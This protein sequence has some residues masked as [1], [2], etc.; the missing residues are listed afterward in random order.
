VL[1]HRILSRSYRYNGREDA[2]EV[3]IQAIVNETPV[4]V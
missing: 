1:S 2:G 4:P 3:L